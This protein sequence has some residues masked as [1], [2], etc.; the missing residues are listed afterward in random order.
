[1]PGL[2]KLSLIALLAAFVIGWH[3]AGAAEE[4]PT[5]LVKVIVPFPPGSTLDV[6]VR[7]VTEEMAKTWNQPVI[8]E[9]ISGAAGNIGTDRF[10]RSEPDGYTLLIAPPG[11]FGLNPLLYQRGA[12][13]EQV[14]ADHGRRHGAE[15]AADPQ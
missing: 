3:G 5:R 13:S 4:F 15:R 9:N 12:R 10:A 11:P 8:I 14:R 7:I 2:H 6:L 1:M